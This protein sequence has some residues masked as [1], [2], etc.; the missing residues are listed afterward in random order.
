[1]SG[2]VP[3]HVAPRHV[4]GLSP[5]HVA[6]RHVQGLSPRHVAPRHVWGLSP[7]ASREDTAFRVGLKGSWSPPTTRVMDTE[8]IDHVA[9]LVADL[10]RGRCRRPRDRLERQ[11]AGRRSRPRVRAGRLAALRVSRRA[12]AR[13]PRRGAHASS[14]VRP[15]GAGRAHL[16]SGRRALARARM[17]SPAGACSSGGRGTIAP[18]RSRSRCEA[19]KTSP[20]PRP[21]SAS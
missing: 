10:D 17:R 5:R 11:P 7:D 18:C 13:A 12:P 14:V 9:A 6:P 15:A 21:F 4:R 20:S 1:M 2:T 16:V 19:S 8:L 3:R